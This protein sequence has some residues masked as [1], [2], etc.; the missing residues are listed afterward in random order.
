M[1]YS[2]EDWAGESSVCPEFVPFLKRS[3]IQASLV[4]LAQMDT[5]T[6][7]QIVQ[8]VPSEWMDNAGIR[9][10]LVEFI[11]SR[12]EFLYNQIEGKLCD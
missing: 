10:K 6:A 7:Q 11:K 9:G 5:S 12:S 3:D 4:R 2:C 1:L 8:S